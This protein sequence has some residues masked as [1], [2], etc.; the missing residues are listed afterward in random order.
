MPQF[1][2]VY[3]IPG[4]RGHYVIVLHAKGGGKKL[5]MYF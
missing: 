3:A 1:G 4:H 5:N 2:Y